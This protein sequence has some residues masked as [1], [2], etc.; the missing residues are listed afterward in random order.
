MVQKVEVI[1]YEFMFYT[2]YLAGASRNVIAAGYDN[3]SFYML[4]F[5]SNSRLFYYIE[6]KGC[7]VAFMNL[8]FTSADENGGVLSYAQ[9]GRR[10]LD[11]RI[12]LVPLARY[13]A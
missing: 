7:Y 4:L 12:V 1:V 2:Q 9:Q 10:R 6:P 13:V 5:A 8:R 3:C 11:G